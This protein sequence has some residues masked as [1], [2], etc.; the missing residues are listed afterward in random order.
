MEEGADDVRVVWEAAQGAVDALFE[1]FEVRWA[2]ARERVLFHPGPQALVRVQFG[3]IGG[4]AIHPQARAVLGEGGPS[5]FRAVGVQT[6]PEREDRARNPAQQVAD[7]GDDLGAGDRAPHQAEV[8]VRVGGDRRDG[9][10]LGPVEAVIEKRRLAAGGPGFA[11]GGQQREAA[12]V[13]EDQ[14]GLQALGFFFKRG[15]GCFIECWMAASSRSR[16][17]RAGFCQ[18]QPKRCSRRQT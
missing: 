7:E 16:A 10:E 2:L 18:L 4:Q 13:Q 17:R 8:G 12:L 14:R 5:L 15:Q 1:D 11:G 9:R 3:R 6:V